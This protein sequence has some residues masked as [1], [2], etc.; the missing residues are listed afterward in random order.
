MRT[1]VNDGIVM[2]NAHPT[3]Q[4][5]WHPV[6]QSVEVDDEPVAVR[7]L[8]VPW[9]LAR[10]P[11]LTA[12]R[13]AC[14]H[15]GAPL[16]AGMI[17]GGLLHCSYHGWAF[18]PSGDCASVPALGPT[19]RVPACRLLRPHGVTERYGLVWLAPEE[20]LVP[21]IDVPEWEADDF[22]SVQL[23]PRRTS[24]G[25][26]AL[27][28]NFLDVTHFP[29]LHA[30]TFAADDDGVIAPYETNGDG[31]SISFRHDARYTHDDGAIELSQQHYELHAPFALRL[32]MDYPTSGRVHTIVFFAQ[33]EDRN[34]TRVYK[35]LAYNDMDDP[36]AIELAAKF[37][38][39]VLEEDLVMLERLPDD[40]LPLA[41]DAQWHTRADRGALA[42]RAVLT[43]WCEAVS[44]GM[45]GVSETS[46]P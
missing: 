27:T 13:D 45:I 16:S 41:P 44:I 28:D 7:L 1:N 43:R 23:S 31:W 26:A 14:P 4:H 34:S 10:L 20:P 46:V 22:T 17:E 32:R 19:G 21:I 38:T 15:R 37:E 39:Q 5:A 24:A 11:E 42:W 2:H 18:E 36:S 6:A 29:Y 40:C 25:A 30:G 3:L 12:F 8:G 9:V 33:P 35:G